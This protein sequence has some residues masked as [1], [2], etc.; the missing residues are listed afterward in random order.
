MMMGIV[1]G[2]DKASIAEVETLDLDQFAQ[3]VSGNKM[4][5]LWQGKHLKSQTTDA[6]GSTNDEPSGQ[7]FSTD[8]QGNFMWTGGKRDS[9]ISTGSTWP[10]A[11]RSKEQHLSSRSDLAKYKGAGPSSRNLPNQ[12]HKDKDEPHEGQKGPFNPDHHFQK[13]KEPPN[14]PLQHSRTVESYT[15]EQSPDIDT[16]TQ[17]RTGKARPLPASKYRFFDDWTGQPIIRKTA[18]PLKPKPQ[19]ELAELREELK[20][21][22]YQEFSAGLRSDDPQTLILRRSRSAV[23]LRQLQ[24][25]FARSDRQPRQL[26]FSAVEDAMLGYSSAVQDSLEDDEDI[27]TQPSTA[28]VVQELMLVKTQMDAKKV[29]S[30]QNQGVAYAQNLVSNVESLQGG[31]SSSLEELNNLYY[32]RLDE[33]QALRATSTDVVSDEK[34]ALTDSLRRLEMLGAKLDYELT[35]LQSRIQEVEDGV[36]DFE[37]SVLDVEAKVKD[38]TDE[39]KSGRSNSW[40]AEMMN[41]FSKATSSPRPSRDGISPTDSS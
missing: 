16:D 28:A 35:A 19:P 3:L 5:W 34:I 26:S 33:Y 37:K 17:G 25:G 31:A 8:D 18:K 24:F 30:L 7:V 15:T 2:R 21:D 12:Q 14:N 32:Q 27:L 22:T 41:F 38:L 39:H 11:P 20:S 9:V 13:H 29:M 23:Q 10:S 1:G 6:L 40:L 4:K 36:G